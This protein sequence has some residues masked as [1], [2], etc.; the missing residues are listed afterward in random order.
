MANRGLPK[1]YAKMGFKRG[2]A[3]YKRSKGS[4]KKGNTKTK[5]RTV[6]RTAKR[7]RGRRRSSNKW[8]VAGTVLK[9]AVGAYLGNWAGGQIMKYVDPEG[10]KPL[11]R[12][13]GA[14]VGAIA[15]KKLL[16]KSGMGSSIATG[17][18]AVL[19]GGA[20]MDFI[21]YMKSRQNGNG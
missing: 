16:G 17:A 9:L 13:G 7:K 6:Y 14:L 8:G 21:T 11:Y 3:A 18:A 4:S 12:A 10:N 15:A 1:K 19:A 2:W 5:T 20:A